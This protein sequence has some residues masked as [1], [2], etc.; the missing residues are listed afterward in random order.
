LASDLESA[1]VAFLMAQTSVTSLLFNGDQSI[2]PLRADK[3]ARLPVLVYQRIDTP[4]IHSK[5][6]DMMLAHPRFQITGW[7]AKYSDARAVI[8]AVRAALNAYVPPSF[9]G[10]NVAE[11]IVE[12]ERDHSDPESLEYGRSLDACIWVQE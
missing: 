7:G 6:G 3:D 10:V 11:I 1:L 5:D 2:F 4:S 9:E 12:D 8:A